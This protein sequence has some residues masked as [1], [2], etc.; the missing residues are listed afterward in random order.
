MTIPMNVGASTEKRSYFSQ[1]SSEY[2]AGLTPNSRKTSPASA[3]R[4]ATLIVE[5]GKGSGC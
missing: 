4:A 1:R 2:L 3:I 5:C